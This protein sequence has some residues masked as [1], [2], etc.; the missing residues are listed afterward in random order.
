MLQTNPGILNRGGEIKMWMWL[1]VERESYLGFGNR[2]RMRKIGRNI[3]SQKEMPR[4]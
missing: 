3:V 2:F 4:E 1:Y